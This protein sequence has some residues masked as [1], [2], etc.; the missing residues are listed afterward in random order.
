VGGTAPG[1]KAK[2]LNSK[3]GNVEMQWSFPRT[4][5]T[6]QQIREIQA[7]CAEI[8]VRFLFENFSYKFAQNS[9]QQMSGGPI[10]ARVTMAAARI[11]MSDWGEKWRCILE[12]ANVLIGML[13][14]YVDDVRNG[15]TSLRM[16]TRW[17]NKEKKFT[18]TEDAKKEDLRLKYEMHETSNA[19]DG[20]SLPPSYKL[21]QH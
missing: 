13:D 8:G 3:K 18:L 15:S 5:P 12:S 16:G 19:K 4:Q 14:G 20:E 21:N 9:Y 7:R 11:V 6:E 17:D 2:E 10:G 1:M